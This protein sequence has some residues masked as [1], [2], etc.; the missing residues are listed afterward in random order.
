VLT[1]PSAPEQPICSAAHRGLRQPMRVPNDGSGSPSR[2]GA[3]TTNSL[4]IDARD[5]D[6]GRTWYGR[7]KTSTSCWS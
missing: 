3:G 7:E 2:A 4:Q 6:P 5:I 1:V